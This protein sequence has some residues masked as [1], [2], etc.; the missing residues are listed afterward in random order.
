VNGSPLSG[1]YAGAKRMIWL[2]AKYANA[3]AQALKLGIS[4]QAIVPQ[5]MVGDTDLGR[6]AAEL[7]AQRQGVTPEQFL[8]GFGAALSSARVGEH[9]ASIL[10]DPQYEQGVAFGLKGDTGITILDA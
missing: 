10:T 3:S 8:A 6:T 2:L 5:Q 4:F 1:G 7:Y 9:V